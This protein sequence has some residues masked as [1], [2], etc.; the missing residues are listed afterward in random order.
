[1]LAASPLGPRGIKESQCLIFVTGVFQL[2]HRI[3][4][5]AVARA[6]GCR[7]CKRDRAVLANLTI[8]RR[9]FSRLAPVRDREMLR[10]ILGNNTAVDFYCDRARRGH[11]HFYRVITPQATHF[12]SIQR[13]RSGYRVKEL[14]RVG[15]GS[16]VSGDLL[17]ALGD[18][19]W[20][21]KY[22]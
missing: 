19:L 16:A 14:R 12:A 4:Q 5:R 15:G 22:R 10:T 13:A 3:P 9:D 2:Q 21:S 18:W 7:R 1:M 20:Q 17:V 8:S 6:P 11:E